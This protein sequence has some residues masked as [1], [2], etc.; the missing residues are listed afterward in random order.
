MDLSYDKAFEVVE[1]LLELLGVSKWNKDFNMRYVDL[2]DELMPKLMPNRELLPLLRN[3]FGREYREKGWKQY[4]LTQ[5]QDDEVEIMYLKMY[6]R[7]VQRGFYYR[8]RRDMSKAQYY[9]WHDF[10]WCENY[11]EEYADEFSLLLDFITEG[12]YMPDKGTYQAYTD[13]YKRLRLL[14]NW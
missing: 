8:Y 11:L 5:V 7:D 2:D 12:L 3:L 6:D 4:V 9:R 13:V 14:L 10:K 1:I